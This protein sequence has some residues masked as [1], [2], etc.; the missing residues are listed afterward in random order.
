VNVCPA[1]ATAP[2]RAAPPFASIRKSTVALAVPLV[3]LAI[4]IQGV[5]LAALHEHPVS[6]VTENERL[7]PAAPIA[8]SAGAIEYVQGAAAWLR[9]S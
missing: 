8:A 5:L 7:P 6:V 1:T 3:P 2:L 4:E 9:A